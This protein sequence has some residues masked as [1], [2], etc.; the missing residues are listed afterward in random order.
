MTFIELTAMDGNVEF[1]NANHIKCICNSN[2]PGVGSIIEWTHA[3]AWNNNPTDYNSYY[4]ETPKEVF[5]KIYYAS[6]E[7][8]R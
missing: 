2:M 1:V 5:N 7:E 4:K 6:H 8:G 3:P